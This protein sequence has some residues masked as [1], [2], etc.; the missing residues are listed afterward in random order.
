MSAG[1]VKCSTVMLG[2]YVYIKKESPISD[3]G[4]P[5]TLKDSL[6][7]GKTLRIIFSN[8]L[9]GSK[10]FYRITQSGVKCLIRLPFQN[11][12]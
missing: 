12:T 7:L 9:K 10:I 5:Q 2:H 4:V 11:A 8:A 3:R 6:W 1:R